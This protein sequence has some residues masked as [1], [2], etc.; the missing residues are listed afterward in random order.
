MNDP[1][2]ERKRLL[3]IDDEAI[4]L[5]G[6]AC[7]FRRDYE[8]YTALSCKEGLEILNTTMVDA[9]IADQRM[10][11]MKGTELFSLLQDRNKIG[12]R[13]ILTGYADDQD[14]QD[15]VSTGY[16]DGVLEK[17]LNLRELISH[18]NKLELRP[19]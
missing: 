4:N 13:L 17:P 19:A 1:L 18:L 5:L 14:I 9:V 6:A 2:P 11:E 8:V 15:A 3:F 12:L 10:P 16:V 7:L